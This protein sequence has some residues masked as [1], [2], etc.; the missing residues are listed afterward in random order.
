M[1]PTEVK[2]PRRR[3]GP[4]RPGPDRVTLFLVGLAMV[5]AIMAALLL[6]DILLS[7]EPDSQ[8]ARTAGTDM[9][10]PPEVAPTAAPVVVTPTSG[11][12][13]PCVVPSDWGM[14]RVQAGD[15]L[16]S[17]AEESGTDYQTL[18]RVNCLQKAAIWKGQDLYLPGPLAQPTF[19]TPTPLATAASTPQ[20]DAAT[21][22]TVQHVE[23][24]STLAVPTIQVD[25]EERTGTALEGMSSEPFY[26]DL[27]AGYLHIALL[28]AD[29]RPHKRNVTWRTDAI[30]IATI[31]PER[32]TVRLL[33][34]PRDLWVD[35]PG[36]GFD[37]INSADLWGEIQQKGNGPETAK[38]TIYHNLGIPVHYYVKVGFQ[39]FVDIIDTLGGVDIDVACALLEPDLQLEPGMHHLDGQMALDYVHSREFS[40]DYDRG[41]RQRKMLTALWEQKV[42]PDIIPKLPKLWVQFSDSYETDIPLDQAISLAS[43]GAQIDFQDIDT[44]S[45]GREQTKDW[46]TPEGA[47]VLL[48]RPAKL[49]ALLEDF[50]AVKA[51]PSGPKAP[52]VRVQ[53]LNGSRRYQAEELAAA[54]L[55]RAGFKIVG[56]GDASEHNLARTQI[57]VRRGDVA[58]GEKIARKLGI[59]APDIQDETNVPDPPNPLDRVDI[60]VILG[61]GYDPC[62]R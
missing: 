57:I 55:K 61:K 3:T 4:K 48:P 25:L 36:H 18:K 56:K 27:P 60:K 6:L 33:H 30:I 54:E 52:K 23:P 15:N 32:K 39:G 50:Y 26:F 16:S 5:L 42:T 31:D 58:L 20:P 45:I 62:Q 51:E 9:A 22:T 35:I 43:L 41:R 37:R 40:N 59:S 29:L 13:P 17:L 21:D 2:A 10:T 34:V 12:P 11:T 1:S 44:L 19:A 7:S 47:M 38:Q 49:R 24:T 28:G 8:M 53:V 14:Y 46:T